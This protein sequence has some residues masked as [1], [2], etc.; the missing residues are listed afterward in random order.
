M[1]Y[2]VG[3]ILWSFLTT[4]LTNP[5]YE[6]PTLIIRNGEAYEILYETDSHVV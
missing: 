6:K 4:V 5:E 2:S 3:A 1:C